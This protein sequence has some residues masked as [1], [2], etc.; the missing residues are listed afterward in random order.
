MSNNECKAYL[1]DSDGTAH[2]FNGLKEVATFG[3]DPA[4]GTDRMGT[5]PAELKFPMETITF[6]GTI[7]TPKFFKERLNLAFKIGKIRALRKYHPFPK[8]YRRRLKNLKRR[9]KMLDRKSKGAI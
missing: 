6:T 7:S 9:I 1:I 4:K 3:Y 5:F 2:E 8:K